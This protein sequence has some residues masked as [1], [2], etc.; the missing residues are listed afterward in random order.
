M[1]TVSASCEQCNEISG[2]IKGGVFLNELTDS[3]SKN[4]LFRGAN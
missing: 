4:T 2:P 1:V 3:F